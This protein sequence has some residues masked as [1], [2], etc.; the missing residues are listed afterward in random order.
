MQKPVLAIVTFPLGQAS[1]VPL[2][3]LIKLLSALSRNVYVISGNLKIENI[4]QNVYVKMVDYQTS[5]NLLVKIERYFLTQLNILRH[6]VSLSLR[7]DLFVFSLEGEFLFIPILILKLLRKKVVMMP[8]GIETQVYQIKADPLSKFV[9]SVINLNST[10][11]D[12]IILYSCHLMEN[13]CFSKF[14]HKVIVAHRHFVD[15]SK[16]V[17]KEERYSQVNVVGYIGRFSEEKGILNLLLSIPVVL[18]KRKDINFLLCGEGEL[19]SKIRKKVSAD[20]L[21]QK[22][23]LPGW[24]SHD[25]VPKYL[26]KMSLLV[27]PSETEGLP[28]ILLE[29]MACGTPALAASVGA[30][31]DVLTE[32]KTGF[33]LK[34]CSPEFI[35]ERILEVFENPSLLNDIGKRAHD[36][37]RANYRYEKTL[38]I[39]RTIIEELCDKKFK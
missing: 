21:A 33:L 19:S 7:T 38:E 25:E 32:G 29:S 26:K 4:D 8:A 34:S 36:F 5:K 31:P 39:W 6:V 17:I 24:V 10:L 11:V 35:A 22:V 14:Q 27:I 1:R 18:K 23:N 16:F 37:V 2:S 3:N 12:K 20:G 9:S 13:T 15:F 28:N 30:I